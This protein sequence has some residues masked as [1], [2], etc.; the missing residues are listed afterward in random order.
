MTEPLQKMSKDPDAV[1][2]YG[3]DWSPW[4]A[5]DQIVTSDWSIAAAEPY[6]SAGDSSYLH[7]DRVLQDATTTT[8]WL[9][10]GS[11]GITYS[12]RNRVTTAAGRTEDQTLK[13]KIREQ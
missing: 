8:V 4:L 6:Q 5:G 11:D 10:K 13:I 7:I 9:S 3:F 1:K 12:V 2:D